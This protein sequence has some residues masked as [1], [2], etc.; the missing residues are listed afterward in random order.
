MEK[1]LRK[2]L[3]E[4]E[5]NRVKGSDYILSKSTEEIANIITKP[6]ND[7]EI[8]QEEAEKLFL[9]DKNIDL[10]ALVVIAD[11]IRKEDVGEYVTHTVVFVILWRQK[12]TLEHIS[13]QWM[14]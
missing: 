7:R 4:I 13:L 2:V 14:K 3:D 11:D 5:N 8:T 10:S 1:E 6:L 12:V 9:I